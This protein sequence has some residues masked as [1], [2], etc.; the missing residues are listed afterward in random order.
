[1]IRAS[2]PQNASCK[3]KG[4]AT[5]TTHLRSW[6]KRPPDETWTQ[7]REGLRRGPRLRGLSAHCSDP[8]RPPRAARPWLRADGESLS[9]ARDA[10]TSAGGK[11]FD[12]RDLVELRAV[13]R[14]E[15]RTHRLHLE[16]A[17]Q[18]GGD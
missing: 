2:T 15:A 12:E 7:S 18:D 5:T 13:L 17:S 1:M 8:G 10:T 11:Q 3:L 6:P 16:R 9:S 14:E 4:H